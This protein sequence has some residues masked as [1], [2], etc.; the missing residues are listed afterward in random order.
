VLREA[1]DVVVFQELVHDLEA[2]SPAL[3]AAY[4]Y[5]ISTDVPWMTLASRLPLQNAHRIA[6]RTSEDRARDP[7]AATIHV[8]GQPVTL[9]GLHA[10][11]PRNRDTYDEHRA[12]YESL[13]EVV[14]QATGPVLVAGDF[15]ATLVSPYFANFL[16]R[17][18]L[19]IASSERFQGATYHPYRWLGIRIDHVL[20]SQDVQVCGERVVNLSGS[21]HKGVV[22]DVRLPGAAGTFAGR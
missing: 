2:F 1:P 21:D 5:R 17:T 11:P 6:L 14:E 8:A 3:A 15:N 13:R 19:R 9:L 20:L 7:L 16:A 18:G 12:Q 22:V 10:T 4:P